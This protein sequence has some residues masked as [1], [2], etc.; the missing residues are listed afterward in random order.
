MRL[1]WAITEKLKAIK[2]PLKDQ[3]ITERIMTKDTKELIIEQLGAIPDDYLEE[4]LDFIAFLRF[5]K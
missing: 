2:D 4:L 3:S 5:R 1:L